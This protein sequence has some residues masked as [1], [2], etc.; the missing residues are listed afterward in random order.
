VEAMMQIEAHIEQLRA[1]LTWCDDPAEVAMITRELHA[2]LAEKARLI[3]KLE[4]AFCAS[5]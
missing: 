3:S 2:A 1:E 4:A 5:E